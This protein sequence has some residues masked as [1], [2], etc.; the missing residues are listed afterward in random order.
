MDTG[1]IGWGQASG[2]D[3]TAQ[4]DDSFKGVLFNTNTKL[5]GVNVTAANEGRTNVLTSILGT[6]KGFLMSLRSSR[7]VFKLLDIDSA[8]P[9]TSATWDVGDLML[10]S[11]GNPEYLAEKPE[12]ILCKRVG[13]PSA[14]WCRI[15]GYCEYEIITTDATATTAFTDQ[16]SGVATFTNIKYEIDILA[17]NKL[18]GD[19]Y[20]RKSIYVYYMQD[21]ATP[22]V[23]KSSI[24]LAAY[25]DAGLAGL[26]FAFTTT[27]GNVVSFKVTGIAATT[28]NWKIQV[29]RFFI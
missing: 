15:S 14:Q 11:I 13:I 3:V 1:K 28:I 26:S 22:G 25:N 6:L 21:N 16:V 20:T 23:V 9:T 18:N 8:K 27:A 4:W 10:M 5:F 7:T 19:V 29:K 24:S 17:V 2:S 12:I